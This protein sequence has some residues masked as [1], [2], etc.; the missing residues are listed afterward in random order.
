MTRSTR[1]GGRARR[2]RLD[3][4]LLVCILMGV[5][6]FHPLVRDGI[7]QAPDAMV[8]FF[9][10]V[11]WRW[12]WNEAVF[13]PRWHT[14][15]YRG[16]GYTALSFN[17]PLLYFSTALL[18]YITPTIQAAFKVVILAGCIL[19]PLGMYLWAKD[20]LGSRAAIVAAAAYAFATFR[21]RELYFLG[22]MAQ[23]LS[24]SLFP[25]SFFLFRR[26]APSPSRYFVAATLVLALQIMSH[27]IGDALHVTR[28]T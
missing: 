12:A 28:P 4:Y 18:S 8:H 25:L 27:S 3:P 19:Y 26:L 16:Y 11:L 20:V 9:R 6:L 17:A 2:L 24:W 21:F 13:W 23:F 1:S 5:F 14:L 10:S 22:G 15:L 7:T